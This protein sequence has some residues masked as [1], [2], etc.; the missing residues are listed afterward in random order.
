MSLV[1]SLGP[2]ETLFKQTESQI[3]AFLPE[4]GRFERLRREAQSLSSRY[5]HPETRPPMYGT[6]LGIKDVFHVEGFSTQAGSQLPAEVLQATEAQCVT[7]LKQAGGLILGKT[8][9]SE[10]AFITPTPTRNPHHPEHTPGGS[11]SGSAAAVAT[12]LCPL[13]LGSQTTGS[14]IRP[15]AFC[16]V[17]AFKPSYDRI[18][19]DGLIPLAP[20][21]DH[22]G[23]FASNVT[24][25]ARAA[26]LLCDDWCSLEPRLQRPVLGIPEGPY[27]A[28]ASE[29][30]R[31][32]FEAVCQ[33]LV[34]DGY[35]VR[36]VPA[37]P[38]FEAITIRHNQLLAGEAAQV[39]DEWFATYG[40]RYHPHMVKL[41]Q[42][43]Q[44]VSAADLD[45]AR[46]GPE[47]LRAELVALMDSYGLDVW[48]SP[49]APGPAPKGLDDTGD[50]IM[51]LPWTHSGLPTLH[52]PAGKTRAGLPLGVQVTARWY[53]DEELMVWSGKIEQRLTSL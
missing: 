53:A 14:L 46:K 23:L 52:L 34:A 20:S 4:E 50:S 16:G 25:S 10:F 36:P 26:S 8:T 21:L 31:R 2:L 49:A 42:R 45:Q 32:H 33:C 11:S 5:P 48:I 19:R 47:Q 15:A 27:L 29:E 51:N 9:T 3:L 7:R 35:K 13:A 17:V 12:G 18:S 40:E 41:I 39:H 6:L 44:R 22:V 30:G 43:G 28:R 24:G 37:M 38:D 1:Q